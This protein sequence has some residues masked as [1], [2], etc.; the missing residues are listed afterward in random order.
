VLFV[1]L[2]G[3]SSSVA[4]SENRELSHHVTFGA[5][6]VFFAGAIWYT[7]S[8]TAASRSEKSFF[9]KWGPV[10]SVAMACVL[11][12]LDPARHLVL[13]HGG[14]GME[15]QLAMYTSDGAL[16]LTGRLCQRAT[17]FGFLLLTGGL[18]WFLGVPEKISKTYA[19]RA[20]PT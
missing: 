16:S 3:A 13:D 8:V 14:F 7:A 5:D 1:G 19:T 9:A 10:I 6:L 18:L 20:L 2:F 15:A 17:Q 11:L 4:S 12:M